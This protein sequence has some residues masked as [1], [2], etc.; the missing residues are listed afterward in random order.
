[1]NFYPLDFDQY[2][3]IRIF[4][5]VLDMRIDVFMWIERMDE[6][7][8]AMDGVVYACRNGI[9]CLFQLLP[10]YKLLV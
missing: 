1:M 4:C 6:V 7:E 2:T 8:K 5:I 9:G 10:L 3:P